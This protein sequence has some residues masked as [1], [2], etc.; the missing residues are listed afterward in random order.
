MCLASFT[1]K[2]VIGHFFP[3]H[4]LSWNQIGLFKPYFPLGNQSGIFCW[5]SFTIKAQQISPEKSS[6]DTVF[7]GLVK[8][9]VST[10]S[11]YFS[12][13]R[14][15]TGGEKRVMILLATQGEM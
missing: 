9:N 8:A 10:F 6:W 4:E 1:K 13:D 11:M 5:E 14:Q 3:F 15:L 12:P 7:I 2:S